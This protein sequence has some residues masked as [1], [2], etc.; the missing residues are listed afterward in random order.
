MPIS[1]RSRSAIALILWLGGCTAPQ[2]SPEGLPDPRPP[3]PTAPQADHAPPAMTGTLS[4]MR[5]PDRMRPA[6]N[7]QRAT[8]P[9]TPV[10][11]HPKT[12]AGDLAVRELALV[13]STLYA[14][15]GRLYAVPLK[16]GAWKPVETGGAAGL[17][18]MTSDG[19][20]LYLGGRD[21]SVHGIDP[22]QGAA[23][24]LGQAASEITGL[25]LDQG[26]LYVA[27]ARD[28]I[29]K[30]PS[31]GGKVESL[32]S[33]EGAARTVSD[34][35]MGDKACFT[36]GERVWRWPFDGSGPT[37]IPDTQGATAL[38]SHRGVLYVGTADGWVL[39]SGDDGKSVHALGKMAS[40]PIEALGTDGSWLYASSGNSITMMDLKS[41]TPMPCH[42]G[43]PAP[44]SSL[45][46]LD[47]ETVLVGMRAQG[48]TSMPR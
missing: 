16:G 27:T 33:A 35:A 37:L 48:L 30:M 24:R 1:K 36:L 21:G 20:R 39:A 10:M 47:G 25:G 12:W 31:G 32:A 42:S 45:T 23:V 15:S 3:V 40:S 29:F 2:G 17:T 6:W 34:L 26:K 46:V 18:R 22:S 5:F 8:P 9:V 44:V 14:A 7:G 43:F 11:G 13:G 38:A 28:G 4:S 19:Q 41:F